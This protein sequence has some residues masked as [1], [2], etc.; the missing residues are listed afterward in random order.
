MYVSLSRCPAAE[1]RRGAH[2]QPPPAAGAFRRPRCTPA[3]ADGGLEPLTQQYGQ[4]IT[5]QPAQLGRGAEMT[6][7]GQRLL[8]DPAQQLGQARLPLGGPAP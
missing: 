7:G 8:P 5:H 1:Q 6:V 2:R 4:V 3:L